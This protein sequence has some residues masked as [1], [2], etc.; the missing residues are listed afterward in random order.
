MNF[1]QIEYPASEYTQAAPYD[2]QL[3][4]AYK[5]QENKTNHILHFLVSLIFLPWLIV[6]VVCAG[7]NGTKNKKLRQHLERS[8]AKG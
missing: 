5:A 8:F 2:V 6:W 4:L 3:E 7:S 1:N